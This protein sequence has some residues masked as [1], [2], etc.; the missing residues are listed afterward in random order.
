MR[1]IR[2]S[3]GEMGLNALLTHIV[4]DTVLFFNVGKTMT[5][6][7]IAQTVQLIVEDFDYLALEDLKVC[8]KNAKKGLYGKL[9]DRID[10]AVI[11]QWIETYEKER[12][13]AFEESDRQH[14]AAPR[15]RVGYFLTDPQTVEE[16]ASAEL[17]KI[18]KNK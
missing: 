8:F 13:K 1:K 7:Q 15:S 12:L 16:A 2:K 18:W 11:I 14:D 9:Y 17:Q 5:Q 4:T 6:L 3:I 10:G